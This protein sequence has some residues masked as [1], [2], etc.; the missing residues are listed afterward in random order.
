MKTKSCEL[1]DGRLKSKL[2]KVAETNPNRCEFCEFIDQDMK[3]IC[4]CCEIP[5]KNHIKNFIQNGN[6]CYAC[7]ANVSKCLEKEKEKLQK[8]KFEDRFTKWMI[9]NMENPK[10]QEERTFL[11]NEFI[12]EEET[13]KKLKSVNK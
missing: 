11:K 7:M 9:A 2:F 3:N 13:V 1:C 8:E 5:F 6:Y 4:T 10:S 12:K